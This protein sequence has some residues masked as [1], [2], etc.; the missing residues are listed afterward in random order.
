MLMGALCYVV[1]ASAGTLYKCKTDSGKF[2]YKDK[3]C[4]GTDAEISKK[5]Y[6]N[7]ALGSRQSAGE[8][9]VSK[10][11]LK[12]ALASALAELQAVKI[13]IVEHLFMNQRWPTSLASMGFDAANMKSSNIEQVRIG[14]NGKISAL[15]P[16]HIGRNAILE[17]TPHLVMDQ[18]SVEWK[19][20][21]NIPDSPSNTEA[22]ELSNTIN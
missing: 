10:H 17:V 6:K 11:Q 9:F 3:P 19:T 22:T 5:E 16:P 4:L 20:S 1:P 21:T 13:A 12:S 14:S 8:V 18:T 7:T 2:V 15:L